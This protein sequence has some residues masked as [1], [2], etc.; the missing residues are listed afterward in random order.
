M[1]PRVAFVV[2]PEYFRFIYEHDL[3]GIVEV[4]EFPFDYSMSLEAFRPLIEYRADFNLFCRGEFVPNEVLQAL[5]G[6]RIALSSEPFPRIVDGRIEYTE[7]SIKRYQAFNLIRAKIFDYVFHYDQ[8]SLPIMERDGLCLSG[9]FPFP[10]ATS[11]Y[12]RKEV[13]KRWDLFFIGRSTP[14]REMIFTSL[15]HH[16]NFLHICHGIWGPELVDYIGASKVCL[17]VHAEPEV[18][19]EPRVQMMLAAGAFVISERL[20]PNHY[21]RPGIDYVEVA[22]PAKMFS[23]VRHYMEHPEE[24][25]RISRSG[26]DRVREVLDSRNAFIRMFDGIRRQ[27]FPKYHQRQQPR[28][29]ALEWDLLK[30][31][32]RLNSF[33]QGLQCD[34]LT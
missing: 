33:L 3:D 12:T 2:Q 20:T 25:D 21:L 28:K 18:S 16:F 10:V 27:E 29:R 19:W 32:G 13:E 11:T 8:A 17:N 15:K 24:R 6:M 23:L 7:D 34:W 5:S 31:R 14:H 1:K 30:A 9:E 22:E 4:R 26:F